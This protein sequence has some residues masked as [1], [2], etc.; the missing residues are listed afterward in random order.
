MANVTIALSAKHADA[1]SQDFAGFWVRL[2][3][4][5]IDAALV[6]V[7]VATAVALSA[8]L[9]IYVPFEATFVGLALIYSP[10][11]L[12][13]KGRTIGKALCGLVVATDHGQPIGLGRALLRE[14]LL[15]PVSGLFLMFGFLWV[16]CSCNKR[17]WHDH[18]ARTV[19]VRKKGSVRRAR[20]IT[21]FVLLANG[22][23]AIAHGLGMLALY[24]DLASVAIDRNTAARYSDR[25]PSS[26]IEV[27]SLDANDDELY[28]RWLDA[29][30]TDPLEY[31][32][33]TA[34]DHQITIFGESHW[35]QDNLLFLN[36]LI[37]ELYH[38]AGV[39][40]L[41]M[42]SCC[43]EDNAGL[44]TLVTSERYD[45]DLA[46]LIAR[47]QGW[48]D[49]GWK[50]YWDVF[51]TVWRLN[52]SLPPGKEKMQVIGID[53][54]W[55]GPAFALMGLG[56]DGLDGPVWEKLRFVR[57]LDGD[58]LRL[59]KRDEI[60][61]RNV[62]RGIIEKG[63]RGIVWIGANHSFIHYR[64]PAVYDGKLLREWPRMGF[65][66]H[67]KYGDRVFQI[68]LHGASWH[69]GT[70]TTFIEDV[71]ALRHN[72]PVGFHVDGSPFG[73]LRDSAA[74]AFRFQP[75]ACFADLAAGYVYLKAEKELDRCRW[76]EGY[77]SA[78][79]FIKHKP[80]YEAR[81]GQRLEDAEQAN[82]CLSER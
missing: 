2:A 64:Q 11:S 40:V 46:L 14:S 45:P 8:R 49:W 59:A 21:G 26:L 25:A 39:T 72:A 38:R 47:G 67:H 81:C 6:Y 1:T 69:C 55:D 43:A 44:A 19:V 30:G 3:A 79:M 37:P 36:R 58:F 75:G 60:M 4:I 63:K 20:L 15:K 48:R 35:V 77:V 62:E 74:P 13:W 31:A 61:A 68:R 10:L 52:R 82:A 54:R 32:V 57:L 76:L 9:N 5:W 18:I 50:G 80:Y 28:A 53:S 22:G 17:G 34:A 16:A 73:P 42:E 33:K 56:D 7:V 41:A 12:A 66:L 29:N 24:R 23:C 65:M 71:S 70:I 27:A 78:E 51:E